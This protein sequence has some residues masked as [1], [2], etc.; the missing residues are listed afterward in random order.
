MA[1]KEVNEDGEGLNKGMSE[2]VNEWMDEW[3]DEPN[4]LFSIPNR[5]DCVL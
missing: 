1:V 4:V 3:I 2:L 5:T